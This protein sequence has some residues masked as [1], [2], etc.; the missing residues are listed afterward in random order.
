MEQ[1][2]YITAIDIGTTKI[3]ALVGKVTGNG[4]ILVEEQYCTHSRGVRRGLVENVED[5]VDSIK[6]C[7]G[8]LYEKTN[9]RQ[10]KVVV[11]IA[12]RHISSRQD[13]AKK[14]R[15]NPRAIITQSEVDELRRQ[16]DNIS[17][18]P[19]QKILQ[20]IP[21]EYVIDNMPVDKA[22]GYQ[23]NVLTGNYYI[24]VSDVGAMDRIKLCIERCGLTLNNLVLEPIASAEAVLTAEEREAGAVL[25]DIGGGTSDMVIY[26]KNVVRVAEVIPCG[27]EVITEDIRKVYKVPRQVAEKIKCR[28]GSCFEECCSD[29]VIIPYYKDAARR[30]VGHISERN[31]AGVIYERMEQII[32][33]VV[34]IIGESGFEDKVS[35]LVLTG[36][37]SLMKH[38]P[39]LFL[40]RTG[41]D[42][43]IGY[44][45]VQQVDGGARG[46][47]S[48]IMATGVGL[49]MSGY[50]S[51][52]GSGGG[53]IGGFIDKIKGKVTKFATDIFTENDSHLLQ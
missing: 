12:G 16:M 10:E 52:G 24:V 23:G 4:R 48:P 26:H 41:L 33:A 51:D 29:D 45:R 31:L 13:S 43:R 3:A 40:L 21:Q 30:E 38:L 18:S 27:G 5:T 7:L 47:L 32:D 11:G 35:S 37:G 39:E 42:V 20:V 53:L 22:V 14:I 28:Y 34:Y 46:T 9:V 49:M 6:E 17:L 2:E 1:S 44:P 25:L 19:G 8:K 50:R 15:Q 36:G